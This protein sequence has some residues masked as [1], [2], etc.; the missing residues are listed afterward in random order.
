[1]HRQPIYDEAIH[2]T[3]TWKGMEEAYHL[4][5]CRSIGVSNFN[6]KQIA[7]VVLPVPTV[8]L[9]CVR[10]RAVAPRAVASR[11]PQVLEMARPPS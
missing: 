3:E 2:F 1:M 11:L 4:G 7:Q 10:L 6:S 8:A 5:L 9:R